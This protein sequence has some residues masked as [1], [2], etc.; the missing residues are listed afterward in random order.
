MK[1]SLVDKLEIQSEQQKKHSQECWIW[2]EGMDSNHRRLSRRIYSPLHL[3][4]LQP[5]QKNG[6]GDRNRTYNLL[7]TSQL[8]YRWATPAYKSYYLASRLKLNNNNRFMVPW[9]GIEPPTRRFSVFCSTD[10]ATEA[11]YWRPGW[12]SNPRPL[13]WQASA[14]TNWATRPN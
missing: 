6:A 9:G 4:A 7:I 2:W 1:Q 10:W 3:A 5:S 14:L 11:K 12:D 13:A 8:L